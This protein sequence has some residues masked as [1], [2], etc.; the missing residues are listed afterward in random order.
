MGSLNTM[1]MVLVACAALAA[2]VAAAL[3]LWM[4]AGVLLGAVLVH[5]LMWLFLPRIYRQE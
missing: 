4:V 5:G 3:R 1:R 2:L